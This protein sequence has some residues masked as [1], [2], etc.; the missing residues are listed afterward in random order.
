MDTFCYLVCDENLRPEIPDDFPVSLRNLIT[1]CW[2]RDANM[3]TPFR[4]IIDRLENIL[5]ETNIL[6]A[7]ARYFWTTSFPHKS[8]VPFGEFMKIFSPFMNLA[9]DPS[10]PLISRCLHKLLV[11]KQEEVTSY[12]FGRILDFLGPLQP[13][14]EGDFFHTL[15]TTLNQRWFHGEL[16]ITDAKSLLS[17]ANKGEFLVRFS[18]SERGH[19]TISFKSDGKPIHY[20]IKHEPLSSNFEIGTTTYSSLCELIVN[21]QTRW[22]L[23][24]PLF[25]SP[26]VTIFSNPVSGPQDSDYIFWV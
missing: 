19:F 15:K 17:R 21:A 13:D 23:T 2:D 25:E 6:D 20:R 10:A 5:V 14:L 11:N 26:F 1:D 18:S 16:S 9:S 3:R 4:S 24:P 22:D 12:Q 8:Q 7:H